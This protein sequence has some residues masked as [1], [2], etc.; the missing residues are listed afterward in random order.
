V[1]LQGSRVPEGAL[2]KV[3]GMTRLQFCCPARVVDRSRAV[4]GAGGPIGRVRGGEL[5]ALDVELD[6]E[7]NV[8]LNVEQ[9]TLDIEVSQAGLARGRK[10]WKTPGKPYRSGIVQK[11]T[12]QVG[13]ARA[14][15]H[16]GSR[17]EVVGYADI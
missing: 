10:P 5:T 13:S 17:A 2:V 8:E 15:A 9:G 4:K 16:A 6:V 3:A 11:Y 7:L 1:G 14:S 12:D